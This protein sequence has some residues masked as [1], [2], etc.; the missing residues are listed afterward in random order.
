[1]VRGREEPA[2]QSSLEVGSVRLLLRGVGEGGMVGNPGGY[3]TADGDH[4]LQ[5]VVHPSSLSS[6]NESFL[7]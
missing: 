4:P 5:N 3:H 7:H 1:M 6:R 2:R